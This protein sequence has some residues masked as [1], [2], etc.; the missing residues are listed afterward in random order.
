M[1]MNEEAS[2]PG[3]EMG[4]TGGSH[5]AAVAPAT[6]RRRPRRRMVLGLLAGLVALLALLFVPVE[7]GDL[8]RTVHLDATLSVRDMP[9]WDGPAETYAFHSLDTVVVVPSP[10]YDAGP[11]RAFFL[12]R[13][14]RA[15]WTAPVAVPVVDLERTAGGLTVLRRG[16]GTQT[17][18]LHL[19]GGDGHFYVLRSVDKDISPLLPRPMRRTAVAYLARDLMSA[20]NPY[21][22]LAVPVLA[23]AAG[24]L[25]TAPTLVVVPDSPRLG[26]YREAFAGLLALFERRPEGDQSGAEHFGHARRVVDTEELL[27]A[28]GQGGG[29]RVDTRAY[30]RARLFDMWIGDWDRGPPQWRW[31]VY[32]DAG[33]TRYVPIPRDRDYAF[34]HFD[35]LLLSLGRLTGLRE[36]RKLGTF[37]A[38]FD[39]LRGLNWQAAGLDRRLTAGLSRADWVTIADSLRRALPDD[40]VERAVAAWPARAVDEAGAR[41]V[42]VLKARRDRLPGAAARY[43]DLLALDRAAGRAAGG[44][45]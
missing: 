37:G 19:A 5:A 8:I 1:P 14:Y 43:H 16:G 27:A 29:H 35:G 4:Q 20:M 26:P 38:G 23:E 17:Q 12:G 39:D 24:V 6:V 33:G 32:E 10:R 42:D 31:A 21:G 44:V 9:Q 13:G 40:V 34:S 30:A 18:S 3:W 15:L 7:R 45:P 22:A 11:V 36:V 41:V 25:H 2:S 28:L